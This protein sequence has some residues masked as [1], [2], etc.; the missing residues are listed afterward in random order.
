[1]SFHNSRL[2]QARRKRIVL[3]LKKMSFH[4]S[5]GRHCAQAS[6]VLVLKKMSFHNAPVVGDKQ[7]KLY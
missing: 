3:V 5:T 2:E 4:N 1:M 7:V 6:I